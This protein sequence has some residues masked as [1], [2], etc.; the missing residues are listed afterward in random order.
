MDGREIALTHLSVKILR[1]LGAW[2]KIPQAEISPIC[3]AK[4]LDGD[5]PYSMIFDAQTQQVDALG[6]LVPNHVI[7][8]ALFQ[9]LFEEVDG[10][11]NVKLATGAGVSDI[12]ADRRSASVVLDNGE[13]AEA[14]LIVA[15]DSRFSETRRQMGISASMQDFS[16][17]AIVCR[18][19][20]EKSHQA[21]AF[22]CFHYERTLAVLPM[23]G[24]LASIVITAPTD[25]ADAIKNMSEDAFN[26]DVQTRFGDRLGKMTLVGERYAYPLVAVHA[27]R[28]VATRFALIG[29]AAVGM[30]PVTAH[31]FNLGLRGQDTLASEIRKAL[32]QGK[33]IGDATVL[34]AYASQHMRV[35]RPIYLGT[36]AIVNLFT[37]DAP[38]AKLLRKLVLRVGNDFPPI[39]QLIT[40]GL[41]ETAARAPSFLPP[42]PRAPLKRL[43]KAIGARWKLS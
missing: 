10:P 38:P 29:D 23:S 42:L 16:R 6:Y 39:K 41:T 14:A 33:D 35:T 8:K 15:A 34:D 43:E 3:E 5:S 20:H 31:G 24:E 1:Q 17:V 18:M 2:S 13:T 28:F 37:N 12:H 19:K 9:T 7:R 32:S 22:E 4:V 40:D 11:A 21:T 30:H 36:N 26:A 25:A 27:D